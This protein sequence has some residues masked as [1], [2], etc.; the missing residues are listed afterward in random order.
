MSDIVPVKHDEVA[1]DAPHEGARPEGGRRGAA[2]LTALFGIVVISLIVSGAFF[3]STQEYRGGRNQ[4]V[5]QRAFAVAEYGLNAEVSNWD[6]GRN[7]PG[8]MAVGE[9]DSSRVY[10]AAGDTARVRIT[11]L[12][13]NSFW[14]VSEGFASIGTASMESKRTTNAY[15]RLAYPSITPKGA[16]TTAG[17]ITLQ[18]AATVDGDNND[19]AGW[20]Q[21]TAIPGSTVPAMVVGPTASVSYKASNVTSSPAVVYDSAAADSNTYVRYGTETWNS[22]TSN[23][24]IKIGG[25]IWNADIAPVGTATTCDASVITNWGEP[26]RPGTVAG[27]YN[28]YPIIYSS[29]SLKL[30]GNGYGQGILLIN[31]DFEINGTFEWFGLVIARDDITKGN[32]AAQIH[33]AV[34]SANLALGDPTNWWTGTQDVE[35]SRC[36]IESALRGSAILTRVKERHWSQL[37]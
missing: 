1:L 15:V 16:I 36:A 33:G 13:P 19:P 22:L 37:Q 4:L 20:T 2:L 6:R 26:F 12:T 21:C 11:R 23:A 25:G 18:G 31:G 35:Y 27:C 24:D 3:T 34:Y 10:V 28:Y 5:E 17:D 8:G 9:V 32:G 29:G 14:V 30:N 7:L